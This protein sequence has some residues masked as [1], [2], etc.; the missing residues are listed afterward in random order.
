MAKEKRVQQLQLIY[1]AWLSWLPLAC[2]SRPRQSFKWSFISL[3]NM[4]QNLGST[5]EIRVL[6]VLL[7]RIFFEISN[8]KKIP[9]IK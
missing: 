5:A 2:S 9:S 3:C 8:K 1:S 7:S 4:T 6:L